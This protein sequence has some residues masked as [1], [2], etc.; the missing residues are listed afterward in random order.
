LVLF[1][2]QVL[3]MWTRLASN[4]QRLYLPCSSPAQLCLPPV[5][6]CLASLVLFLLVFVVLL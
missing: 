4:S 2:K 3:T 6:S 5:L 1:L